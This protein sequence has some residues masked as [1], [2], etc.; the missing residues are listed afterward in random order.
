MMSQIYTSNNENQSGLIT[1]LAIGRTGLGKSTYAEILCNFNAIVSSSTWSTTTKA[2]L[3]ENQEFRYLDT[4]GFQ[5]SL[6]K[7]DHD[8]FE[9]L[10]EKMCQNSERG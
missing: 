2:N 10:M 6:G 5:D 1:I 4:V 8:I 7:S 9:D 3:Y